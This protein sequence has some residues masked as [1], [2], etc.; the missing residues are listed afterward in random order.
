MQ[1][2]FLMSYIKPK[3]LPLHRDIIEVLCSF[4]DYD[5]LNNLFW[6]GAQAPYGTTSAIWCDIMN[7]SAWAVKCL[8]FLYHI[9]LLQ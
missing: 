8:G 4:W 7:K 1:T 6:L 2:P 9:G 5:K 3:D